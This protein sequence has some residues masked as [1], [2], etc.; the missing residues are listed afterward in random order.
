M[1]G[2]KFSFTIADPLLPDCPLIGCSTG[3]SELCGYE[4]KDIVGR[5]CRFLV[6][7]VPREQTDQS[8]RSLARQFSTAVGEG[9]TFRLPESERKPYMPECRP[10]DDGIFL[11][12]LN[13]R[14]DGS[15]F[16]NMFYLKSIDLDD[17]PYIIGLQTEVPEGASMVLYHEACR[18]LDDNMNA[19]E[20]EFAKDFWCSFAMRRQDDRDEDDGFIPGYVES[21]RMRCPE[22][23]QKKWTQEQGHKL[24]EAVDRVFGV[25]ANLKGLEF[26]LTIADPMLD[27]CPLIGCS[28]G[29]GKLCGYEMDEIVG[30]NCKFLVD[31]V[32]KELVSNKVKRL[33]RDFCISARTNATFKLS[34]EE[35][36]PW[37][38]ASRPSD[39]GLFCAQRNA[40]KDGTL[41]ANMFYLR[42]VELDD[43]PYILGLQTELPAAAISFKQATGPTDKEDIAR[44]EACHHAC[45][46]LDANMTKLEQVL[47]STFWYTGPMRRQDFCDSEDCYVGAT[48]ILDA[49]A[50]AAQDPGDKPKAGSPKKSSSLASSLSNFF[51]CRSVSDTITREEAEEAQDSHV[52]LVSAECA[53]K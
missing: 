15:L 53:L 26:S 31:P 36:E 37:M 38:P 34:E 19:V 29:F 30:H 1:Q 50:R 49:P 47:A 43:R 33:A 22:I 35:R 16:R 11:M 48:Y 8:V 6:D 3:F 14:K 21:P 20:Q 51:C 39:D 2:L 4:S 10:S 42:R 7:P 45:R 9:R 12:Q 44:M 27:T 25:A 28:S 17:H 40:K 18:F 13:A 5:N 32:P 41:F 24:Q 52:S 23:L 46:V